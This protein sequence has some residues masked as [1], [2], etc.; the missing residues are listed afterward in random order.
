MAARNVVGGEE[1]KGEG[2]GTEHDDAAVTEH[3]CE[4]ANEIISEEGDADD[5]E[6]GLIDQMLSLRGG[7]RG[8]F[9]QGAQV[10]RMPEEERPPTGEAEGADEGGEPGGAGEGRAEEIGDARGGGGGLAGLM[11]GGGFGH[12]ASN[13]ED[14]EGRGDAD[15]KDAFLGIAGELIDDDDGAKDADVDAAL[16]DGGDPRSPAAR[17]GLGEETGADGPF[18]ANAERGDETKEH[19]LPPGLREVGKTGEN[20][21]GENGEAEGAAASEPIA[22]AAEDGAADGPANKK[23]GL[24]PGAVFFDGGGRKGRR[25]GGDGRQWGR[26]QECK[27]EVPGRRRTSRARRRGRISIAGGRWR[28]GWGRA[29]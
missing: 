24:N 29:D 19:E 17:P 5:A 20:G 18:A 12:L 4:P 22:E 16:Q 21:V 26:R 13:P 7:P 25:P 27:D 28:A 9:G 23:G 2:K 1:G 10:L 3:F 11:P 8:D 14:D 6:E 15:E